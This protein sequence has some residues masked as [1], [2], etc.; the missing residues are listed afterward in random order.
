VGI[1]AAVRF[2]LV[3]LNSTFCSCPASQVV[4]GLTKVTCLQGTL[5]R[6]GLIAVPASLV[7]NE[8]ERLRVRTWSCGDEYGKIACK[9]TF[10][11]HDI[12]INV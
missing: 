8:L 7:Y 12:H 5:L 3:S 9:E 6:W 2:A 11:L 4:G 10:V 1:P